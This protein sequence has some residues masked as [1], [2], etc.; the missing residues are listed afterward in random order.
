MV[1]IRHDIPDAKWRKPDAGAASV[2]Y[3]ALHCRNKRHGKIA[4]AKEV[5]NATRR[6]GDGSRLII[7]QRVRGSVSAVRAIRNTRVFLTETNFVA[8]VPTL[9]NVTTSTWRIVHTSFGNITN[10]LSAYSYVAQLLLPTV[11]GYSAAVRVWN[12]SGLSSPGC[13]PETR[14]THQVWGR[15]RIGPRFHFTVPTTLAPI[16]YL[17]FDR[18]MTWS[19]RKLFSFNRSCTSCI[20]ICNPTDIRWMVVI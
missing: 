7:R 13:Y 18:I 9:A 3:N 17:S 5:C 20:Q 14:G 11:P 4:A 6:V 12:Q 10:H 2:I 8:D 19:I 16:N 1:C 15:V